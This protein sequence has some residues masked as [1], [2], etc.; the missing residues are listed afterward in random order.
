M[1]V[2]RIAF[3]SHINFTRKLTSSFLKQSIDR[4]LKAIYLWE[5]SVVVGCYCINGSTGIATNS[6]RAWRR[7]NTHL[8][9]IT[10]VWCGCSRTCAHLVC[11][12]WNNIETVV[13]PCKCNWRM[14][15]WS[16]EEPSALP[17]GCSAASFLASRS[18]PP[19]STRSASCVWPPRRPPITFRKGVG[20]SKTRKA[21]AFPSFLRLSSEGFVT[22]CGIWNLI[23]LKHRC[24]MGITGLHIIKKWKVPVGD[25][26]SLKCLIA[27]LRQC[28]QPDIYTNGDILSHLHF[29]RYW[30]RF[31]CSFL[32]NKSHISSRSTKYNW[33][34]AVT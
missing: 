25:D 16:D 17:S 21:D 34:E 27:Q 33:C 15:D 4:S 8:G 12:R 7:E 28:H 14:I 29:C 5:H 6:R 18:S 19:P 11:Q 31:L 22:T 3:M 26:G 32:H 20:V 23:N 10:R 30:L 9:F 2:T 1:T 24:E 13:A